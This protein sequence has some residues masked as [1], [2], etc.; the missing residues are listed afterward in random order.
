M[1]G[2]LGFSLREG[3]SGRPCL[4]LHGGGGPVTVA[5]LSRALSRTM[6]TLTPTH[7]GWDGELPEGISQIADLAALYG[8][9]LATA[10]LED[11]VVIGSSLGGWIAAELCLGVEAARITDLVLIDAV[12]IAVEGETLAD[13]F[14][15]D[16]R[17][18]AEHSFHDADRFYVDPESLSTEQRRRGRDGIEAMRALVGDPYLHDPGLRDRLAGIAVPTLVIW[19]ED[20]RIASAAYGRAYAASIPGARFEPVRECGHVPQLERPEETLA[21]IERFLDRG[22]A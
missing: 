18:V 8:R 16:A 10:D 3:G 21:L 11:V 22:R 5:P 12:G 4:V 9:H 1:S 13:F 7:P 14:A 2:A 20:D 19:G 15:L 6:R 17:G